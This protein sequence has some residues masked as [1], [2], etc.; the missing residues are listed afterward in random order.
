MIK[1]LLKKKGKKTVFTVADIASILE[2]NV[3]D[4][5]VSNINY[6]VRRGELINLSKGLYALD[7]FD[8]FELANKLRRPSYISFYTA[9][10]EGGIVFQ[11]YSTIYLACNRSEEIEILETKL[12][13][14][15]L[16]DEILLNPLGI[17]QGET[18]S[19]ATVERA[20][21]DKIYLDGVEYFDNLESINWDFA[22]EMADKVYGSKKLKDNLSKLKNAK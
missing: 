15:K 17:I 5:L 14:R 8:S 18:Y 10:Q 9:L 7:L 20:L 16:K 4:N 11:E 13:Y 21:C 19:K 3:D 22:F 6:Y 12:K 2:R 1:K